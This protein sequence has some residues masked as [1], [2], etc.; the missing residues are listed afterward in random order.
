MIWLY[1]KE[2]IEKNYLKYLIQKYHT[3][4]KKMIVEIE[5]FLKVYLKRLC[6]NIDIFMQ[7]F[8]H[9]FLFFNH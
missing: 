9:I 5:Y 1:F 7:Y 2:E 6:L 4:L 3:I 8:S